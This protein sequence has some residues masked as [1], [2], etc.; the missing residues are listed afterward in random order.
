MLEDTADLICP[1]F[2]LIF[3]FYKVWAIICEFLGDMEPESR[4]SLQGWLYDDMCHLMPFAGQYKKI[5]IYPH[6]QIKII[7]NAKQMEQS[8]MAQVFAKLKKAVDKVQSYRT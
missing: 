8:A 7:E 6:K 5:L 3:I 2:T 1:N 4:K